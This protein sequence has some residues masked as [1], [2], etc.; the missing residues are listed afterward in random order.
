MKTKR[1]F[2]VG[3]LLSI[4]QRIFQQHCVFSLGKKE[5]AKI[6]LKELL[7]LDPSASDESIKTEYQ[8]SELRTAPEDDEDFWHF[9]EKTYL[10]LQEEPK[11][12]FVKLSLQASKDY[13]AVSRNLESIKNKIEELNR[14]KSQDGR[15]S[16]DERY[17]QKQLVHFEKKN[18]EAQAEIVQFMMNDIK[19]HAISKAS[20]DLGIKVFSIFASHPYS[21]ARRSSFWALSADPYDFQSLDEY[22]NKFIDLYAEEYEQFVTEC[23]ISEEKFK[24]KASSYINGLDGRVPKTEDQLLDLAKKSHILKERKQVIETLL[25]HFENKDFISFVGMAPLQIEGI[26]TDICRQTY[27]YRPGKSLDISSL[28]DKLNHLEDKKM[29]FL[30]YEYYSFKFP[31]IRNKIAHGD[32]KDGEYEEMALR[33][34]L[35]LIPVCEF[36][37]S[38]DL[39]INIINNASKKDN[40]ALMIYWAEISKK[41]KKIQASYAVEDEI[42]AININTTSD[43]FWLFLNNKLDELRNNNEKS[44]DSIPIKSVHRL[45]SAGPP[46]AQDK[47]LEILKKYS[48]NSQKTNKEKFPGVTF[49]PVNAGLEP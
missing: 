25:K 44:N 32:L 11:E 37:L 26:F 46:K 5:L 31:V 13:A 19:S 47:A 16:A 35:D 22:S 34:I 9:I 24:E 29:G 33:L 21:F 20:V 2:T 1:S 48:K 12:L 36:T 40:N 43:D 28:N 30:F 39:P 6:F 7:N 45:R 38:E 4:K 14:K 10:L 17:F 18:K 15:L 27:I 8:A 23:K 41:I 3:Q 49:T 42:Q